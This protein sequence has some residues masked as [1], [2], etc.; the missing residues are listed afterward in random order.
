MTKSLLLAVLTP[1][2]A[3]AVPPGVA[4]IDGAL[5]VIDAARIRAD[6]H[7]IASDQLE[8]R[9]TPSPGLRLAARYIR[10]RLERLEWEPGAADGYFYEYDLQSKQIDESAT[11]AS[12]VTDEDEVELT[13]GSDWIFSSRRLLNRDVTA[14]LVYMGTGG[15][16]DFEDVDLEGKVALVVG[17]ADVPWWG[18][19]RRAERSGAAGLV[20][21]P[22]PDGDEELFGSRWEE[23]R[24]SCRKGSPGWPA[25]PV[26]EDRFTSC[27]LARSTANRL[28]KL[29]GLAE[30]P[31][32]GTELRVR[33][34]DVRSVDPG[35]PRVGVE[36][37]CGLWPG[38]DPELADEVVLVSAHYDHVGRS[39]R[40]IYNG[41]DDNGSGTVA[42]LAL[43]EALAEH[44]PLR[45][46]VML[47][48]VSGEEK[49]L[50]GSRAWSL[51][52]WLPEGYRAVCN[53]NIDMVGRNAPD[54][55]L[56]TPSPEHEKYNGMTRLAESLG[57]L[58]GFPELGNAD[59]YYRRSDHYMFEE[60][61]GI[62]ICFL[63]SDV[64]E[65][66]HQPTDTV[67]KIDYDKIRRVTRLVLRMLDGLQEDQLDL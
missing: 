65:D 49:G 27:V 60:N 13:W 4:S 17:K 57:E 59:A 54:S 39:D 23:W 43:A 51:D 37:V 53:V 33:F 38:S 25:D 7:F 30:P 11:V 67:D 19:S 52:P 28:W 50:L 2:L 29:A 44:G 36:N 61:M 40:G 10:A 12:L 20:W 34:R 63:F 48:W 9:D 26:G 21:L 46:T 1:V 58:E 22:D 35:S 6:L 15:Q 41:A 5:E 47:M 16:E 8:G 66:Y 42:L 32:A 14:P 24:E 31:A 64:H 3:A 45:R 62:P 55:L 56:V 18:A